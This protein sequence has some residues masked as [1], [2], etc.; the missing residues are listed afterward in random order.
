MTTYPSLTVAIPAYNEEE[1]IEDVIKG[2]LGQNF[3]GLKEIL[4]ADGGSSDKTIEIVNRLSVQDPRVK[5]FINPKRKQSYGLN[6]L[7][8]KA[9]GDIFLRADCH[10]IY[11][12]DYIYNCVRSLL[13]S[14]ALNVGGAQRFVAIDS[15]QSGV[16]LASRSILG[17]GSAKYRDP[18]YSGYADTVFLG[19]FWRKD[20]VEIGGYS[21]KATTN[22]DAELNLRLLEN[23]PQAVYV[24]SQIKVW[25][26]PRSTPRGL[27]TQYFK[28]GRGRY[29][30]NSTHGGKS[31]VRTKIPALVFSLLIFGSL[32]TAFQLDFIS[33]LI[34]PSIVVLLLL[35]ESLRITIKYRNDFAHLFWRGSETGHPSFVS[36]LFY[37]FIALLIM[38]ISYVFGGIF[39][40]IR[41]RLFGIDGW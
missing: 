24:S 23:N 36:R 28:Y 15:F 39:Q 19:C 22:E 3:D 2:F 7:L 37:C 14:K 32:F 1:Y 20:L 27:W 34:I 30:T 21:E 5:L 13:A 26:Y 33:I 25:Y 29:I 8:R 38:P 6:I 40:M 41:H 12:K 17:N 16:C 4:V 11:G 35:F 18:N 10:C 9:T 31:P